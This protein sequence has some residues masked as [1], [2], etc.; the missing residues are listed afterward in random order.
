MAR[1]SACTGCAITSKTCLTAIGLRE[2]VKGLHVTSIKH[3]CRIRVPLFMPGD[4]V[5]VELVMV[6]D[7][8]AD[9]Y[10][11]G[12][13][14]DTE[15][16]GVFLDQTKSRGLVFVQHGARARGCE[17]TPGEDLE[18][19]DKFE[20]RGKGFARVPLSRMSAREGE[21]VS[22]DQ[23]RQCGV[24]PAIGQSCELADSYLATTLCPNIKKEPTP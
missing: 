6:D 2:A 24:I 16:P 17:D 12:T 21:R 9:E 1:L 10:R 3:S 20:P 5:W 23:C 14:Y 7:N 15:Y 18:F 4:P 22:V 11:Q 19:A 8:A 13:R